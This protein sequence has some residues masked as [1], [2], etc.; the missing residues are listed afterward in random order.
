MQVFGID[1]VV[2]IVSSFFVYLL[3]FLVIT[4]VAHRELFFRPMHLIRKLEWQ[5]Y[6]LQF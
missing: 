5:S 4:I 1:A 2:R 3:G 6:F